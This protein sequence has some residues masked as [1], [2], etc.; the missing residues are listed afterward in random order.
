MASREGGNTL[1]QVSSHR[2]D[3]TQ[4]LATGQS[5]RLQLPRS[6]LLHAPRVS[7]ECPAERG[8]HTL[9]LVSPDELLLFG[10]F[11]EGRHGQEYFND[12]KL[13][14]LQQPAD[15]MWRDPPHAHA[16]SRVPC[17]RANHTATLAHGGQHVILFGGYC[18][19]NGTAGAPDS[20]GEGFVL[21][22]C[23]L[24]HMVYSGWRWEELQTEGAPPSPRCSHTAVEWAGSVVVFGGRPTDGQFF[25]DTHVLKLS[26]RGKPE[27]SQLAPAGALPGARA[28]HTACL[29]AG[30]TRMA[31]Y[32]GITVPPCAG[33]G[34]PVKA[35]DAAQQLGDVWLLTLHSALWERVALDASPLR[36]SHVAI[37]LPPTGGVGLS[38]DEL[39][40]VFGGRLS[41]ARLNHV[42]VLALAPDA[43]RGRWSEALNAREAAADGGRRRGAGAA[44]LR[45]TAGRG[46]HAMALLAGKLVIVGGYLG[47]NQNVPA[48]P[49]FVRVAEVSDVLEAARL[50]PDVSAPRAAR[51]AQQA[52]PQLRGATRG[53]A[54][55]TDVTSGATGVTVVAGASSVAS[56]GAERGREAKRARS[57]AQHAGAG[58]AEAGA[59]G[60]RAD[61][62]CKRAAG[63]GALRGADEACGAAAT[64]PYRAQSPS[65]SPPLARHGGPRAQAVA[66]RPGAQPAAPP[67][68]SAGRRTEAAAQQA[69]TAESVQAALAA[70]ADAA[71]A[72]SSVGEALAA[73][74]LARDELSAEA[75]RLRAELSRSEGA[76][77]AMQAR[78]AEER[79]EAA[80]LGA[81]V[82]A[83][84]EATRLARAER[85]RANDA[86]ARLSELLRAN[87][88]R[89]AEREAELESARAGARQL[90][91]EIELHQASLQNELRARKQAVERGAAAE[92]SAA[93]T[94]AALDKAHAA[95]AQMRVRWRVARAVFVAPPAPD[96]TPPGALARADRPNRCRPGP[97][98]RAQEGAAAETAKL[99][100]ALEEGRRLQRS[101]E[102]A[103]ARALDLGGRLAAVQTQLQAAAAEAAQ[104]RAA[105]E[106]GERA[107]AELRQQA[108]GVESALRQSAS[109][110]Q[111]LAETLSHVSNLARQTVDAERATELVGGSQLHSA[112]PHLQTG[113]T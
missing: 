76:L 73:A 58:A 66:P 100:S 39:M 50:S 97:A 93:E 99:A 61:A 52:A 23:H 53:A 78:F 82:R 6:V 38:N 56:P 92:A 29:L 62:S 30:G 21:G 67:R 110:A 26:R 106:E 32:G 81:A 5:S 59:R 107:C 44:E 9:T 18:Q 60:A 8:G 35:V 10:G 47:S 75:A 7:G 94:R 64:E 87:E 89:A 103:D 1:R 15:F 33:G 34:A 72:A 109:K 13:L 24:L 84:E 41:K 90:R 70:A 12:L 108:D 54:G 11:R 113:Q 91:A 27:W 77:Q 19:P 102:A 112:P 42:T 46:G 51:A 49:D 20:S 3:A 65:L 74:R 45:D 98:P 4:G 85:E 80:R 101:V 14:A 71:A 17:A 40:V 68:P 55:F 36:S 57:P 16:K 63:A 43:P 2:T 31:V 28:A 48:G 104:L 83:G 25:N 22:D 95:I 86:M 69:P 79:A 88:A 37:A 96:P 111:R 105:R